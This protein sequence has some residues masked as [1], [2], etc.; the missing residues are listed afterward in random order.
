MHWR[1]LMT[2]G[3][4]KAPL[5]FLANV[6]FETSKKWQWRMVPWGKGVNSKLRSKSLNNN[7]CQDIYLGREERKG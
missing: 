5:D 2:Q 3:F 6:T 7:N 1:N 4:A